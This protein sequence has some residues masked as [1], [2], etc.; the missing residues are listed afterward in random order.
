[1]RRRAVFLV[2]VLAAL[3]LAGAGAALAQQPVNCPADRVC[4]PYGGGTL[5]IDPDEGATFFVVS[6]IE[7]VSVQII[8]DEA[9]EVEKRVYADQFFGE[10]DRQEPEDWRIVLRDVPLSEAQSAS[11]KATFGA[12]LYPRLP[13]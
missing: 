13:A 2:L 9:P 11:P 5:R 12:I 7:T 10:G 4:V 1:M 8:G 3:P 6:K